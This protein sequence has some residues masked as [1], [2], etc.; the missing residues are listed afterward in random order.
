MNDYSTHAIRGRGEGHE[1]F[2]GM[3]ARGLARRPLSALQRR[4]ILDEFVARENCAACRLLNW[5]NAAQKPEQY[6]PS[7]TGTI[8]DNMDERM[9]PRSRTTGQK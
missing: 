1:V 8:H 6:L 9:K 5:R 4:P 2:M 7:G 3:K